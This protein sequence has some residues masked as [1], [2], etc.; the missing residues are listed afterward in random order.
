VEV[1]NQAATFAATSRKEKGSEACSNPILSARPA[2]F[3]PAAYGLEELIIPVP[4]TT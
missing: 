1:I 2:G 4:A 3:E